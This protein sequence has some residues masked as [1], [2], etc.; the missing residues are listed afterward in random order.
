[1]ASLRN[2]MAF[3]IKVILDKSHQSRCY[4]GATYVS[5][6]GIPAWIDYRPAIAHNEVMIMDG[7][8]VITVN[9]HRFF[10][11]SHVTSFL[12]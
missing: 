8:N 6:A 9:R 1:M 11:D 5:N 12:A 2:R 7:Q 10:R 4:S 3:C